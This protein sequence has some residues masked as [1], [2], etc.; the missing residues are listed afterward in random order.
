M[1]PRSL[2]SSFFFNSV[3]QPPIFRQALLG[4]ESY[5]FSLSDN[6]YKWRQSYKKTVKRGKTNSRADTLP[7]LKAW[8]VLAHFPFLLSRRYLNGIFI[9]SKLPL[10]R[11]CRR[12]VFFRGVGEYI[13]CRSLMPTWSILNESE[14][15][16]AFPPGTQAILTQKYA[17]TLTRDGCCAENKKPT[18]KKNEAMQVERKKQQHM[19]HCAICWNERRRG[20]RKNEVFY[21]FCFRWGPGSCDS[22]MTGRA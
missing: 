18:L 19:R 10:R 3:V 9:S 7:T 11:D 21:I 22:T 12:N 2:V 5:L 1:L 15:P 17:Q 16:K 13:V 6:S 8:G 14:I 20:R 4:N